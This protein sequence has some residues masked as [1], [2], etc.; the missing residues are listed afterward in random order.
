MARKST[1][2]IAN[3]VLS[4]MSGD[5]SR[6]SLMSMPEREL[7][8]IYTQQRDI[9]RKRI[10][11]LEKAGYGEAEILQR[12]ELAPKL[13]TI[14]S[15]EAL[16]NELRDMHLFLSIKLST[17]SGQ[18]KYEKQLIKNMED[19]AGKPLTKDEAL[20]MGRLLDKVA[21]AVKDK[22]F[23]YQAVNAMLSAAQSKSIKN[24][25]KFFKDVKFWEKNIDKLNQVSQ[26][27]TA[28]GRPSQSAAAYRRAIKFYDRLNKFVGE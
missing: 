13:S 14:K 11:A 25:E 21:A 26:I 12:F 4:M 19:V 7:R 5:W 18:R 17:V 24:P 3:Q 8:Q 16:V 23:R 20:A 28:T 22:S 1:Q 9:E 27:T 10:T 2:A 15:K 6:E